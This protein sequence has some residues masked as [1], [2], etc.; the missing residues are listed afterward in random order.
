MKTKR[1]RHSSHLDM[2]NPLEPSLNVSYNVSYKGLEQFK[3]ECRKGIKKL[4]IIKQATS[5]ESP[6]KD[7][8][9]WVFKNES[10]PPPRP[11]L[12][13]PSL[14]SLDLGSGKENKGGKQSKS[15]MIGKSPTH[16]SVK[17]YFELNSSSHENQPRLKKNKAEGDKL[18]EGETNN[19]W[20]TEA[21]SALW[22]EIDNLQV[23]DDK[24][25]NSGKLL[26]RKKISS[27]FK[28]KIAEGNSGV[29]T[30]AKLETETDDLHEKERIERLKM[31]YLRSPTSQSFKHNL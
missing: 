17:E 5:E 24:I 27:L 31:K 29:S 19:P 11:R 9:F 28:P 7:G 3:E 22:S 16:I 1:W 13:I 26:S 25:A 12:V 30:E 4:N 2:I 14:K 15:E 8:L 10:A 20:K 23:Q 18:S 21:E 6:V